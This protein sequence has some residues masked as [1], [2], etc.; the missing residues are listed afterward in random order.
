MSAESVTPITTFRAPFN[1]EVVL[2]DVAYENGFH[3]MRVR[4]RE[5]HRFTMLDLDPV[6]AGTLRAELEAWLARPEVA[7]ITQAQGG[8]G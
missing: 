2:Q 3:L 8:S 5:G 4:I 7:A 1:K 6:T